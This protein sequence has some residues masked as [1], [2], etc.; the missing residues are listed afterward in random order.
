MTPNE[1]RYTIIGWIWAAGLAA[2][3]LGGLLAMLFAPIMIPAVGAVALLVCTLATMLID[4]ADGVRLALALGAQLGFA[5]VVVY[6][7]PAVLSRWLPASLVLALSLPVPFIAGALA[8]L[9]ARRRA[10]RFVGTT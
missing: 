3:V 4:D 5:L 6:G 2:Y 9:G 10:G 7:W 8:V 1:R